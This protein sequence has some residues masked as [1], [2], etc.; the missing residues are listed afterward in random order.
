MSAGFRSFSSFWWGPDGLGRPTKT[1]PSDILLQKVG[2][3][4]SAP[5][6]IL[7][8]KKDIESGVPGNILLKKLD[9]YSELG[10]DILQKRLDVESSLL[11]D[12]LMSKMCPVENIMGVLVEKQ[13]IE[14]IV[15]DDIVIKKFNLISELESD[16]LHKRLGIETDSD[17]D[18][19]VACVKDSDIEANMVIQKRDVMADV[20]LDMN[21]KKI[22]SENE[23]VFDILQKLK[24]VEHVFAD[25]IAILLCGSAPVS[26]DVGIAKKNITM[27]WSG[28][29]VV[30]REFPCAILEADIF[31]L[32]TRAIGYGMIYH[33]KISDIEKSYY[34]S[35]GISKRAIKLKARKPP[36]ERKI[37]ESSVVSIGVRD[38]DDE[39]EKQSR[40]Y[41]ED[42]EPEREKS[43]VS[44]EDYNDLL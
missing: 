9:A 7:I 6:D 10:F 21:I 35:I 39:L 40:E 2:I 29:V 15:D 3:E 25:D 22:N 33:M 38:I 34:N 13:N 44:I 18:I 30:R 20:D 17:A 27:L 1:Y 16:I 4:N 32:K 36:Y 31:T 42:V 37:V 8:A 12:I 11:G 28:D 5:S 23:L 41:P 19:L 14:S 43:K 24:D 26:C